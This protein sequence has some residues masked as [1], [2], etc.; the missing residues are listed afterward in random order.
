MRQ[1][2]LQTACHCGKIPWMEQETT[3][4]ETGSGDKFLALLGL[5][6][7]GVFHDEVWSVYMG[8]NGG[9]N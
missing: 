8:A 4:C 7:L 1:E 9:K 2:E 5:H 6:T 3:T